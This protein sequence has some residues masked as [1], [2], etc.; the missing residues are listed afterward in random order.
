MRLIT[1]IKHLNA[2]CEPH[3]RLSD[4]QL[5]PQF[6]LGLR[7]SKLH[8]QLTVLN[9]TSFETCNKEAI[10]LGDNIR[11]GD[12]TTTTSI[13]SIVGSKDPNT[14]SSR[15]SK[16][17]SKEAKMATRLE[18]LESNWMA[19]QAHGIERLRMRRRMHGRR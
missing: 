12:E 13:P 14:S 17:Q 19:R 8:D 3:E 11:E 6:L 9:I 1:K 7:S 2:R 15:V 16:E 18:P 10:R 4:E 5:L